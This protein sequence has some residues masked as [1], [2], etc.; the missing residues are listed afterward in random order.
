VLLK[1]S[2]LA[3]LSQVV[4][5]I[6]GLLGV[7]LEFNILIRSSSLLFYLAVGDFFVE[8]LPYVVHTHHLMTLGPFTL[9]LEEFLIL[10]ESLEDHIAFHLSLVIN[11]GQDIVWNNIF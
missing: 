1:T 11:D 8:L 9:V 5:F 3:H 4:Q 2:G 7:C 6:L 10:D